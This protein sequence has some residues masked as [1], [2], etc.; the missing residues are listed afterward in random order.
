MNCAACG[1]SDTQ[2]CRIRCTDGTFNGQKRLYSC[3]RCH[4]IFTATTEVVGWVDFTNPES[5]T[6]RYFA[7][8]LIEA[9]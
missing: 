9:A 3:N 2:V 5:P 8:L 1:C 4:I 6:Q 7:D